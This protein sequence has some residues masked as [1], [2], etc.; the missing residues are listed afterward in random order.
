MYIYFRFHLFT[1]RESG[2]EGGREGEKHHL[3]PLLAPKWCVP[4]LG[5]ESATFCFAGQCPIDW[6]TQVRAPFPIFSETTTK[7]PRWCRRIYNVNTCILLYCLWLIFA[8]FAFSKLVPSWEKHLYA[9]ENEP[10][11]CIVT[12]YY[13][14]WVPS[15]QHRST[16]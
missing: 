1:F 10:E 7:I 2:R 16:T 14:S 6:A 9:K 4:W 12:L 8:V 15:N 5:I 3:P 11:G 13:S